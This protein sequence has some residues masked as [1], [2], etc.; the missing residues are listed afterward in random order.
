MYSVNFPLL[1]LSSYPSYVVVS[2]T[3]SI[4]Q[5]IV[6]LEGR[7]SNFGRKKKGKSGINRRHWKEG[8]FGG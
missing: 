6:C 7:G 4:A 1:F 3:N 5:R 2:V 8:G